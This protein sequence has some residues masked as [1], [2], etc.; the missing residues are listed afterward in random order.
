MSCRKILFVAFAVE[1]QERRRALDECGD[2]IGLSITFVD[3]S[4]KDAFDQEWKEKVRA[5][6]QMCHGVLALV[7]KNSLYSHAQKWEIGCASE[8]R[9]PL[10]GIWAYQNDTT[11]LPG[12]K[13]TAWTVDDIREFVESIK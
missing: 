11:T 10:M 5:R 6:I 2:E 1:D 7:S 3:M 4:F 13:I 9:K 12:T 8:E